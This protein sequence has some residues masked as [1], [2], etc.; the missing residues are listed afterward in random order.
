MKTLGQIAF[1]RYAAVKAG[2]TYDGKPIPQWDSLSETTEGLRVQE[3][4]EAA[5]DAV[6]IEH[7]ARRPEGSR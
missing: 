5:A 3:A 1:D 6:V 2:L 7:E 4:W